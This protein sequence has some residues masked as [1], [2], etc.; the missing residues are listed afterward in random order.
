M[1]EKSWVFKK[2]HDGYDGV[3]GDVLVRMKESDGG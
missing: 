3:V 2:N 1:V